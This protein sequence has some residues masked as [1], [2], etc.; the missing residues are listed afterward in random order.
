MPVY[1]L[2]KLIAVDLYVMHVLSFNLMHAW[3]QIFF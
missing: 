1:F 2:I 3:Y